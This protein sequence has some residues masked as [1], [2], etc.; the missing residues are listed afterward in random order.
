MDSSSQ[1]GATRTPSP[2]V[3]SKRTSLVARINRWRKRTPLNPYWTELFWVRRSVAFLAQHAQGRLLDVG[4]GERPYANLF[5]P[6]VQRYIG[7]EYPPMA[8]NL[9]PGIWKNL[10]RV[11][12]IIDVWGDGSALPFAAQTFD[13]LLALEVLEHVPDPGALVKDFARVL[14]P[15]GR[16]LLSVPFAAPLH[17][18]PYD[19]QRFTEQGLRTLV[20]RCGLRVEIVQPRGNFAAVIGSLRAQYLLRSLGASELLVDGSV[21][22]SRWRG[23]FVFLLIA[24]V[25]LFYRGLSAVSNDSSCPM[26]YSLVARK[27]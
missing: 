11:R 12:G 20:E 10:E 26:G 9:S 19:Y 13:T 16:L 3:I 14:R 5:G 7:L 23:P 18:L 24:L 1:A 17:Q 8:D 22:V 15:G 25:Q 2:G 6:R 4:V 27:D 21:R